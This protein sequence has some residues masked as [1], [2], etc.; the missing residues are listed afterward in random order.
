MTVRT[1]HDAGAAARAWIGRDA[2]HLM[3]KAFVRGE[4]FNVVPSRSG[5]AIEA[6]NE[7]EHK[8]HVSDPEKVP[9]FV[10]VFLDTAASAEHVA[11]TVG[12][13]STGHRLVVSTDAGP[14][15]TIGLVRLATLARWGPILGW[16]EDLDGQRIWTPPAAAPSVELA[17]VVDAALHE[18]DEDGDPPLHPRAVGIVERALVAERL[19]SPSHVNGRFGVRKRWAYAAWQK[20]LGFTGAAANGV[21]G[22]V[23]LTKLGQRHGFKVK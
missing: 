6:W 10:P 22:R 4:V 13:D 5:T 21:P 20:R 9:A 19:L 12:R 16:S 1:G 23:S 17:N 14:N 7:A 3:C 8:H 2:Y 11:A 18:R 15:H